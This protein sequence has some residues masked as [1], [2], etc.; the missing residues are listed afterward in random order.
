MEK[1][2]VIVAE[3]FGWLLKADVDRGQAMNPLK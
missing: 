2:F 1:E 3:R